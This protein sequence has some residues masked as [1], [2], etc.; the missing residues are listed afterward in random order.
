MIS[1]VVPCYNGGKFLDQLTAC[2]ARQTF[3]DFEIVLVDDGS[4]D[5]ATQAKLATLDPAI[6]VI[7]QENRGMAGARNTGFAESRADLVM[8]LDCD[9]Q[10]EPTYLEECLGA[11]QSAPEEVGFVFTHDRSVGAR[12]GIKKNYFNPFDALFKNVCSYGMLIRKT[13]WKRTGGYDETMRD[14]YEDWEFSLRLISAGYI[15]VEI[16]KPLFIYNV[17]MQGMLM[18]RSSPMHAALWRRIRQKHSEMYRISNLVRLFLKTRTAR[19]EIYP[20]HAVAA[21]MLTSILPDSWYSA[22]VHF[23][24]CR[25]LSRSSK[26]GG[27]MVGPATVH[28]DAELT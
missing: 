7:H 27:S 15:G 26:L 18:S 3:R 20:F 8:V 4:T 24:R 19:T 22:I 14:G 1:V 25:R 11:L 10:L 17:S 2:L 9:D 21:L 6:R 28:A 13:A 5:P 23:I 12:Q 16:P